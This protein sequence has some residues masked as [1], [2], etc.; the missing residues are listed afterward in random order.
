M[1]F[2]N[3]VSK[4]PIRSRPLKPT[5]ASKFNRADMTDNENKNANEKH[6]DDQ[7]NPGNQAGKGPTFKKDGP[8]QGNKLDDENRERRSRE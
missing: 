5:R 1:V 8:K 7:F 3:G 4:W 6:P 2:N